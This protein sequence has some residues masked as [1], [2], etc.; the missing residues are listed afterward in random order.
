M[1]IA[2]LLHKSVE[3]DSRVRR[4]ARALACEGH[5]VCVL[6]LPKLPGEL[7]GQLDGFEVLAV[8]PPAWVRACLPFSLYRLVFLAAFV[9][10]IRAL[11]PD[12]VHAHDA[13]MLFPGLLGS[14]LVGAKLVYDTHEYASGVPY[15]ERSWALFVTT[16]ERALIRRCDAVITVSD[17]IADRLQE[18]YGLSAR[19]AVVRN[20]C[21]PTAY[22][23]RGTVID[24]RD[25]PAASQ[26]TVVLHLGAV[27]RDR[28][29]ATL[30]RA[31]TTLD[32]SVRLVF[33]GAD[34]N[35]FV[36]QLLSLAKALGVRDRVQTHGSVAISDLLACTEQAD[37]GVSL[38]EDTC[39][40]HRLALPNKV[41]EYL[42]AGLPVVAS[43]LPEL[44]R[45]LS[46]V[47]GATL[48][49]PADAGA[50]A[51]A[52]ERAVAGSAPLRGRPLPLEL[53]WE[54]DVR[55]LVH[56]YRVLGTRNDLEAAPTLRVGGTGPTP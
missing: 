3:H 55:R 12:V 54:S 52:I 53:R 26:A 1:R 38:L 33:L 6:H 36:D 35:A 21:D 41:F 56:A 48:V 50:V 47:P 25:K 15:R 42:A 13:A 8:T 11:G 44:R 5:E 20:T 17:G 45:V 14:R 51:R 16:L 34:D 29:C 19:P 9:R 28:G 10:A 49:N 22:R 39:E 2:M 40:N 18:R 4:E 27:A 7:N 46:V 30:I 31:L 23:T 32:D 24:L 43:D 37:I